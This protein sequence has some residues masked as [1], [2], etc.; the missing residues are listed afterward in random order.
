MKG[1]RPYCRYALSW[2][3]PTYVVQWKLL[4]GS[5]LACWMKA[6][7]LMRRRLEH[8]ATIRPI[9]MIEQVVQ[10][11]VIFFKANVCT[12]AGAYSD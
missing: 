9:A 2:E 5:S 6:G 10:I 4:I 8:P 1:I 3:I 7:P 11:R 12:H